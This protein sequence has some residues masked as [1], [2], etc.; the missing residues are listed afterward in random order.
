MNRER[1]SAVKS[2]VLHQWLKIILIALF[3]L[4]L[5]GLVK[6]EHH[7][8]VSSVSGSSIHKIKHIVV[9][10]QE[11]RSF[12]SYFGTF[13]GA[14]GIPMKEGIPTV[15]VPNPQTGSCVKPYPDHNDVNGG[16]PHNARA[17]EADINGGKMSGFIKEAER[18]KRKCAD[19]TDPKCTNA[20]KTDVMG[21]H[22]EGDIPNYW[23]YAK[24][25][26][27]QDHMYESVHS[28]S[29]PSHLFLVSGWSADCAS[30]GDPTS[31]VGSL[32][33]KNRTPKDPTPF[34]WTDITYLLNKAHVSWV[35]YLDHGA[36]PKGA[37]AG[38]SKSGVPKI[39]NVLPGFSDVHE[40]RQLKNIQNLSNFYS[41]AK[42]GT[43]PSVSW[44]FP[45]P[46]D[47]EHPPAKVSVGQSYVTR[48]VNA[49]MQSP[50]WKTTAIF[51][52]WDDWG[53]FY[54]NVLP[55]RAD[56]LGYGIRVP[57]IVIS[58]YAKKGYIDHQTLSFDAYLKFIEDDFLNGQRID[59][60]TDGRPDSRPNVRENSPILGNLVNDFDF[61]MPPRPPLILPVNP[62]TTLIENA[63]P[64]AL[65][66]RKAKKAE[67]LHNSSK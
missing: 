32:M 38:K 61:S 29:F 54:D 57:G 26:V 11:N 28:W 53:G 34:A 10:F 6:R 3:I 63:K 23:A 17:S 39:W 36:A 14:L 24:D 48:L 30:S 46:S 60:K 35:N 15:C 2:L 56:S 49:V 4:G 22:S 66:K 40:D 67:K 19:P 25:F 44:I 41:A 9:I 7:T 59:P 43:L 37:W 52:T 20:R 62:K 21:Y 33:P 16:G 47:S 50:N 65:Q 8:N 64:K 31:C 5:A 55:P 51:I 18:G 27:L 58:P 13:P 12:D 45:N 42:S 1:G